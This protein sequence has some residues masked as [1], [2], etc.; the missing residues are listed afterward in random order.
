M[1]RGSV[2][3]L[4]FRSLRWTFLAP[5][6]LAGIWVLGCGGPSQ[7]TRGTAASPSAGDRLGAPH[8]LPPPGGDEQRG[9]SVAA[10]PAEGLYESSAPPAVGKPGPELPSAVSAPLRKPRLLLA[11][12]DSYCN[13]PD[14]MC[15]LPDGNVLLSVP[16]FNDPSQPPVL[17]KI[18]PDNRAELFLELPNNPATGKPFGPMGIC[19]APNGDLFLADNQR[20]HPRKSRVCRIRMKNGLP[21]E[22]GPAIEGFNIA[23]AVL[24]HNGYLFVTD[25]QIDASRYPSL[26]GVF[27]FP[28]NQLDEAVIVLAEELLHDPHL[29]A[30]IETYDKTLPLGAD[31]LCVDDAGNLYVGNVYDGTVHRMRFGPDGQVIANEIFARSEQMKSA[32]GL[33]YDAKRKV[34]YVADPRANAVHRVYLDGRVETL[35]QNGDTDGR[36]GSLDM[37]V[38]VLVR[39]DELI[40]SNMDWPMTGCINS[41]FDPPAT[42]SVISLD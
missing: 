37:P 36:D 3:C 14:A 9:S 15:L 1:P 38:E 4:A 8:Q 21:V 25:T 10:K 11:L 42:L 32:D 16:N 41:T 20:D 34:I 24:C 13:T 5:L 28:L 19:L 29:V 2:R 18:T 26:S 7:S 33:F 23:N 17:M 39:G 12:P 27:R 31:G 22:I 40:I 35:A 30:V 6:I